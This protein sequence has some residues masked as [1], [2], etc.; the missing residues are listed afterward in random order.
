MVRTQHAFPL[1]KPR[2]RYHIAHV[3]PRRIDDP[4]IDE[5]LYDS[6]LGGNVGPRESLG[7]TRVISLHAGGDLLHMRIL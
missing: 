7:D 2:E 6:T 3:H 5:Q 4:V 1:R